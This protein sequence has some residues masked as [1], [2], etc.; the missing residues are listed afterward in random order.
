MWP[1]AISIVL[2][3]LLVGVASWYLLWQKPRAEYARQVRPSILKSLEVEEEL[4][5][6]EKDYAGQKISVKEAQERLAEILQDARS[7]KEKTSQ[8][9]PPN[10]LAAVHQQLLEA[11]NRQVSCL[12]RHQAYLGKQQDLEETEEW[13]RSFEEARAEYEE[14]LRETG[15]QHYRNLIRA[16]TEKLAKKNAEY[17]EISKSAEELYNQ[18]SKARAQFQ[19]TMKEILSQL[20]PYLDLGPSEAGDLPSGP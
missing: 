1:W 13:I 20:G 8:A 12:D 4:G 2:L 5:I 19:S 18:S 14:G 7:L 6:V 10:S 16:Y 17:Q 9:N 15:Y 11:L 3:L